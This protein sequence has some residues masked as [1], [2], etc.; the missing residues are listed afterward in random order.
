MMRVV[1]NMMLRTLVVVTAACIVSGM[2]ALPVSAQG[3]IE[4]L[5]MPGELIQGHA[6]Y[7]QDCANCHKSFSKAAQAQLCL[8]C[9]KDV[10]ADVL[11]KSRF[12]GKAVAVANTDCRQCHADHKGRTADIVQLDRANFDHRQTNFALA[13]RHETTPCSSCHAEG[14]KFRTAPSAC[15]DCHRKDDVHRGK[16]RETCADCHTDKGWKSTKP[17]DHSKTEFAL[18]GVHKTTDCKSCH[19]GERY[20]GVPTACADCHRERDVHKGARGQKC[21]GC[22]TTEKW[23][24]AKFDHDTQTK[25]ALR[26]KHGAAPCEACHKQ[27]P[28]EVKLQA[29]CGT[30]HKKDDVHKGQLGVDCQNCHNESGFKIGVLF[31]HDKTRF[32]LAGKHQQTK[33]EDCHKTK[34][35]KDAP[36]ACVGCHKKNDKHEGRFGPNCAQC[37][38]SSTQWVGARFDHA[39]TRFALTGRHTQA[40]CYNCHTKKHVDRAALSTDCYS[41]HK[42]QDRHKG[43]FGRNCGSCHTT[44]T[45]GVA[46]IKR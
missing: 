46:Y 36:V 1:L 19:A 20:K 11:S 3:V 25:F 41:C 28:R 13:G 27:P 8:D 45:F 34:A 5:I 12:H 43:A 16:L 7:E 44:S 18:T 31:D 42:T 14:K 21:E 23:T 4:R 32:P 10:A 22:H 29:S 30:C 26:G 35:Y 33:C 2:V 17:F 37:H 24:V 38:T 9:H 39:K 6:K 15:V 40:G